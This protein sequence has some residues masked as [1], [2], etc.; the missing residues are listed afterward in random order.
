MQ[1]HKGLNVWKMAID[2][3]VDVYTVTR[4]YP[5]DELFAM[6]SQM[7]RAA[8]SISM[9]I[10]EGYG[11]GTDKEIIH[12]LYIAAGSASESDTQLILSLRLGYIDIECYEK[13]STQVEVIRKM[14]NSLITSIKKKQPN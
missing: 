7:R 4:G 6:V 10:A 2:Y 1:S 14:L 12:F 3:A 5:K 13:L 9:N 8:S 11:R